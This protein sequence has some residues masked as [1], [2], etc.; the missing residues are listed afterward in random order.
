VTGD[1]PPPAKP[2]AGYDPL[3]QHLIYRKAPD[4]KLLG[5][6]WDGNAGMA[7]QGVHVTRAP[8]SVRGLIGFGGTDTDALI[9]FPAP[10]LGH[11]YIDSG[12]STNECAEKSLLRYRINQDLFGG[13]RPDFL[14]VVLQ[15]FVRVS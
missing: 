6:L 8:R 11:S 12:S 10:N 4:V 7:A 9:H 2:Y 1:D 15:M 14:P 5:N 3:L 13:G